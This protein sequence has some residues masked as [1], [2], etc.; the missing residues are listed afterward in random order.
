[1]GTPVDRKRQNLLVLR[2]LCV[3]DVGEDLLSL[4]GRDLPRELGDGAARSG[5]GI[6]VCVFL[7]VCGPAPGSAQRGKPGGEEDE[8]E[9]RLPGNHE[10]SCPGQQVARQKCRGVSP[11]DRPDWR[12][13][14]Q[15]PT[16]E[17]STRAF[18]ADYQG[19][20]VRVG[21]PVSPRWRKA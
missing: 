18:L 7:R 17:G 13:G 1:M 8:R 15:A 5:N 3:E 2:G 9:R 11:C 6:A 21:T 12:D 10:T 14:R 16:V 20:S 19:S 4:I